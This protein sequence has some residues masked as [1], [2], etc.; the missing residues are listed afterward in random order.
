MFVQTENQSYGWS[1]SLPPHTAPLNLS[2]SPQPTSELSTYWELEPAAP[3]K[4][5]NIRGGAEKRVDLLRRK[6]KKAIALS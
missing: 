4:E 1:T 3:A 5:N 6:T 2:R